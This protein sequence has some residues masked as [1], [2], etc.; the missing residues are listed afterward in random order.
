MSIVNLALREES[1]PSAYELTFKQ[2][3]SNIAIKESKT[4]FKSRNN[5]ESS[6]INS[7]MTMNSNHLFGYH[8]YTEDANI[9]NSKTNSYFSI[10]KNG[11]M[12]TVKSPFGRFKSSRNNIGGLSNI[13]RIE[14]KKQLT[15]LDRFIPI[16][17]ETKSREKPSR[18][19]T[20]SVSDQVRLDF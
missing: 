10:K 11:S 6:F 4:K 17:E 1:S 2:P 14:V 20:S 9:A 7:Q 13:Y 16:I 12:D 15:D 3:H 8:K 18:Q 5:K 19:S